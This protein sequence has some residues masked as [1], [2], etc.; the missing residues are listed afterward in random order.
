MTVCTSIGP[1][2]LA[3]S[4]RNLNELCRTALSQE[5]ER[6]YYSEV[7]CRPNL[8]WCPMTKDADPGIVGRYLRIGSVLAVCLGMLAIWAGPASA[9]SFHESIE[10]C[11]QSVGRPIVMACMA[12][13]AAETPSLK[14]AAL[15]ACRTK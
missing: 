14:A 5:P 7:C 12:A 13:R 8:L 6:R 15:E 2:V 9:F 3:I 1:L 4:K 11:R 10:H